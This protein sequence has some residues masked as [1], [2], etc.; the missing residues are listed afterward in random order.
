MKRNPHRA[1]DKDGNEI[2]P[3]TVGSQL[4]LGLRC[5]EIFCNDCK[6]YKNGI[7]VSNLPPETPIPDICLRYVC[8]R[9]G[10]KNLMSRGDTHEFYD[11]VSSVRQK[12]GWTS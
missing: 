10:S 1:Y 7:D 9:C 3:A 8:S 2:P 4:A 5:A 6:H 12:A 11:S